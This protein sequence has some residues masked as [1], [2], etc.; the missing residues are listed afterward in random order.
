MAAASNVICEVENL[1]LRFKPNGLGTTG[2]V[3][4]YPN[5][6][7]TIPGSVNF[8]VDLRNPNPDVLAAMDDEFQKY[9]ANLAEER[10]VTI[11]VDHF[12]YFAPVEF[13]ASDK[14]K[15]AAEKLGLSHM[16][17]YAGAGH[18]ACYMADLV[19]TGMVFTP[20]KDGISHNEIEYTTPEQCEAGC[21]VLLHAMLE[22]AGVVEE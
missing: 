17:I 18:D 3:Q 19:P 13:N 12:W 16:D 21:N 15:I 8:S 14:V 1:A 6:R 22:V 11:D 10:G 4:V 5:S 2:F 20:C 7:N 9:C